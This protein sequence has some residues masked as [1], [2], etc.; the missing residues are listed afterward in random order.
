MRWTAR[1]E[2]MGKEGLKDCEKCSFEQ[3]DRERAIQGKT[4]NVL[5]DGNIMPRLIW[6]GVAYDRGVVSGNARRSRKMPGLD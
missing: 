4:A 2:K 6:S 5:K 3:L 1:E